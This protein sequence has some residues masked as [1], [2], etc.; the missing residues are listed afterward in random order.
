MCPVCRQQLQLFMSLE[1]QAKAPVAS[2]SNANI[3]EEWLS[4]A[5]V[6]TSQTLATRAAKSKIQLLTI[7]EQINVNNCTSVQ[8]GHTLF[9]V[10]QCYADHCTL[11]KD[12]T[13][14]TRSK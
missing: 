4:S 5:D 7:V 10:S 14:K 13:K 2:V 3:R 9:N 1:K 12:G 11:V 8:Y 6:E